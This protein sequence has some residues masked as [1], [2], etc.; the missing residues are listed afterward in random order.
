[1]QKLLLTVLIL[2]AFMVALHAKVVS[3]AEITLQIKPGDE[4]SLYYRFAAGDEIQFSFTETV[5]KNLKL[6]EVLEWPKEL[7]YTA[8]NIAETKPQYIVVQATGVYQF[9]FVGGSGN[10]EV[11]ITIKRRPE[12]DFLSNFD[13]SV[14]WEIRQDTFY[15][16][17]NLEYPGFEYRSEKR[18]RTILLQSDTAAVTVLEKTE[19]IFPR[20]GVIYGSNTSEMRFSLPKNQ[21]LPSKIQAQSSAEVISWAYWIGVGDEADRSFKDANLKAVAKLADI[22]SGLQLISVSGG[23]GALALLALKGVAMFSNPPKGDNVR[24]T[25][26]NDS[27]KSL[28]TG[29][30][31]VAFR[32]METPL[33]GDFLF[34][35]SNDNILEAINV[36]VKVLAVV[37]QKKYRKEDYLIYRRIAAFP[38]K[39]EGKITI[40]EVRAPAFVEP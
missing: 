22:A 7:V 24:Y 31:I 2:S 17:G 40:R 19:R 26:W 1:M 39:S 37:Q 20:S 34:Q 16:I 33:Q 15:K 4:Q 9:R 6:V 12:S 5:G 11:H 29:S 8:Q 32:R 35:L 14:R 10:R 23:Y 27:G 18:T 36:Q 38:E 3:V 30:S 21:Y 28:D 13:T 25:L